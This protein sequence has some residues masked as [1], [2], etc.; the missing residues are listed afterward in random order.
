LPERS[1]VWGS[2]FGTRFRAGLPERGGVWD[3]T[4]ST[5]FRAG[6]PERSSVRDK[7]L[8][9]GFERACPS[10]AACTVLGDV[11]PSLWRIE[12][13]CS[14]E[15]RWRRGRVTCD[16][17]QSLRRIERACSGETRW[18]GGRV[19]AV[20]P[21]R[22]DSVYRMGLLRRC[23]GPIRRCQPKNRTG[24]PGRWQSVEAHFD[25]HSS[26]CLRNPAR[27]SACGAWSWP[28]KMTVL[29]MATTPGP[30]RPDGVNIRSG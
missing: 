13:A 22:V 15:T 24:L 10:G 14:G 28:G 20:S 30:H 23:Q 25:P 16:V 26:G 7:R 5:R 18:R 4:F 1:G 3:S 27:R 21:T 17:T 11:T 19:A 6:L 2:T 9:Q 29:R 12:R 8:T